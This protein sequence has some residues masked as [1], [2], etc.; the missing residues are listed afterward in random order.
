MSQAN[1][2]KVWSTPKLIVIGR[3]R[4]EERVLYT[5]KQG[6]GVDNL[7]NRCIAG[8]FPTA[9]FAYCNVNKPS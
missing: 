4:S 8:A 6:N 2:I 5:C 3:S 7:D 9:D 1:P